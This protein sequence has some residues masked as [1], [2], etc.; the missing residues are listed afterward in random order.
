MRVSV[1]VVTYNFENYVLETLDSIKNQSYS[2]IEL[3]ITDD[4]SSDKTI[5]LVSNWIELNKE[6]FSKVI[7]LKNKNNLGVAKN[8]N[9]GIKIASGDWI[10]VIAGDDILENEALTNYV[11]FVNKNPSV[12]IF[13]GRAQIFDDVFKNEN[14]GK[15]LPGKEEER[16]FSKKLSS[17][18]K[19]LLRGNPIPAPT[20]FIKKEL[21][22]K[23]NYFDERFKMVEDYP[24]WFKVLNSGE[25]ILYLPKITVFYR[26]ISTSVSAKKK[27]EEISILMF[28]FDKEFYTKVLSKSSKNILYKWD[29][30][31]EFFIKDKIVENNNK[32]LPYLKK[33]LF[34]LLYF[35]N[36]FILTNIIFIIL[37]RLSK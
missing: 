9:K 14:L 28:K 24:F 26:K 1:V 12:K 16:F 31:I 25:D 36:I 23:L 34:E 7:F 35:K 22:E 13:F 6:R 19:W 8:I 15:V 4:K 21:L 17:K 10:K 37:F 32:K 5:L 29:K 27:D 30:K 11:Y 18:K 33:K 2:E 3:I 20:S